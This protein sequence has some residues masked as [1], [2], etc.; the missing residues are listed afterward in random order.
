MTIKY[1]MKLYIRIGSLA[2]FQ[3][4]FDSNEYLQVVLSQTNSNVYFI[5]TDDLSEIRRLL[6]LNRIKYKIDEELPFNKD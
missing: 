6:T 5:E 1:D 4:L 2:K 3:R